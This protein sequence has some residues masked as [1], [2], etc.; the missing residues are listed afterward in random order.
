MEILDY[1]KS[2]RLLRRPS[3]E[4]VQS[5]LANPQ[6][7]QNLKAMEETLQ[8]DGVGLAAAQVGW[9]AKLF[10]LCIDEQGDSAPTK[11]FINPKIISVSKT[12]EKMNEGCLSFPGLYFDVKRPLTIQWQYTDIN[13]Q[14]HQVESTGFF[15]RAVMHETD[16]C[17]GKVF[18]DHATSVQMVKVNRW[19]KD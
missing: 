3:V 13:W 15:A 11:V 5:D 16:H 19:M 4:V 6:F 10:L 12:T 7:Q 1:R 14:T 17:N 2:A 9:N 18:I 8:K